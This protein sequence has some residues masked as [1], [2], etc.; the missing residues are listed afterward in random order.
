MQV[1][2]MRYDNGITAAFKMVDTCAAEFA[3]NYTILLFCFMEARMRQKKTEGR[4]EG[5][6]FLVLDLSVSD[7]VLSLTSVLYIVRG[8]LQKEGYE[9]DYSK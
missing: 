2:N 7:R 8:H 9:T 1:K 5:S 4:K 3:G 6:W